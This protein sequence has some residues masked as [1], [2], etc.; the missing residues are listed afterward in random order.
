LASTNWVCEGSARIC[1]S[2][3]V[4]SGADGWPG[5]LAGSPGYRS[6]AISTPFAA[7]SPSLSTPSIARSALRLRPPS[8]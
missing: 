5:L 4:R 7:P 2:V 8:R 3:N 1:S 6:A